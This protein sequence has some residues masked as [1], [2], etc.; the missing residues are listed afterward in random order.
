MNKPIIGILPLADVKTG[1][2]WMKPNY[3]SAIAESGGIPLILPLTED[4]VLLDELTASCDGFLLTG[5]YD[6]SPALY[7]QEKL[8]VC[9]EGT[10]VLDRMEAALIPRILAADKP[11]LGICRGL[12]FLNVSLGGT[13]WQDLPTQN[14]SEIGHRMEAPYDRFVHLAVQ[15]EDSPL[16]RIIP[17]REFRVNS[18]HHQAICTLGEGLFPAA[19]SE[20]GLVEAICLPGKSFVYAVQWHPEDLYRINAN[21]AALFR[22]LV[23]AAE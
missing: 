11:V 14:P 1:Y 21:A 15:P 2:A 16:L 4:E 20:D 23:A 7:G 3:V 5:G 8:P 6:I 9:G 17:E 12:Q 10:E 18:A 13:L 19:Y 22:A